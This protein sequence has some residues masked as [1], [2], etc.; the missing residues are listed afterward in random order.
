MKLVLAVL[1]LALAAGGARA[2]LID[3]FDTP[4][5]RPF[6]Q[7]LA[8]AVGRT[9]PV[10]A[11]S[12][13][14]R[15]T[16]N[17]ETSA[18]ERETEILGQLYLERAQPIG[19]NVLNVNFTY[20][21]VKFDSFDGKDLNDLR[22]VGV[23]IVQPRGAGAGDQFQIP[24]FD[25][26]LV[27]NEMTTSAT[28]GITDDLEVNLTIPVLYTTLDVDPLLHNLTTGQTQT[29]SENGSALGVGDI[30]LRAKYRLL[31]GSWGDVAAGLVFRLPSGNENNFQGTGDFEL[32]PMLYASTR[33][34]EVAP[35]MR[36]QG[37]VNAGLDFVPADSS[38]SE[39]RYGIGL[40]CM[41]AERVTLSGAFLARNSFGRLVPPGT[42]DVPRANGTRTPLF[43]LNPGQENYYDVSVG[44]RVDLWHDRVFGLFNVI[45][46]VNRDGVRSNVIPLVGIEATF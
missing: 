32:S 20:Q 45:V 26:G 40:D 14:V 31:R 33:S 35:G 17:P 34:I 25:V 24:R 44:G 16:F 42:F 22:D 21:W 27:T 8:R 38:L 13:G 46:P 9:L 36:L 6:G 23:P 29:G 19:K 30:F 11:A 18:F 41:L 4:L 28:Y 5:L 7:A 37:Y 12:S 1:G 39:G 43:G 2:D 3:R 15:F 10:P